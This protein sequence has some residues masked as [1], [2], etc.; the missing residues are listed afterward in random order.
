[1]FAR[2]LALV[3]FAS[4]TSALAL[5]PV[6]EGGALLVTNPSRNARLYAGLD[7]SV[8]LEFG[9]VLNHE[10]A[11]ELVDVQGLVPDGS[12]ARG[13]GARYTLSIDFLGKD[14]FTP[15]IG[16]GV[17]GGSFFARSPGDDVGGFFISGR[18]L[19][20]VRYTFSF[21]LSLKALFAVNFYGS[22]IAFVPTAGAAWVF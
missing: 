3:V 6:V 11:I 22:A 9:D 5:G 8:G 12:N 13:L 15:T 14:G 1:M 20:G 19:A 10:L 4:S 17:G 16:L 18:A 21:G 7:L 2:C